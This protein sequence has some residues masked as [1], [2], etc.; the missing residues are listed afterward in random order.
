MTEKLIL[1]LQPDVHTDFKVEA[2][3]RMRSM[4]DLFR[5]GL[6]RL[7]NG[8][9]EINVITREVAEKRK[10]TSVY[11]LQEEEE[12]MKQLAAK[13]GVSM[14]DLSRV[15][16]HIMLN[17]VKVITMQ[18][19]PPIKNQVISDQSGVGQLNVKGSKNIKVTTKNTK[20]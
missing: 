2:A 3:K 12:A 8:D 19:V 9:V 18:Q 7:L 10:E 6:Y 16:V 17:N 1:R 4:T 20:N 11:I 15:V 5:E 14:D 13:L